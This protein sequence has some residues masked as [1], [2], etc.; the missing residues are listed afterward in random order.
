MYFEKAYGADQAP[1]PAAIY[2]DR[3]HL[4]LARFS[5]NDLGR[6]SAEVL[7]ESLR[8]F[9]YIGEKEQPTP[10]GTVTWLPESQHGQDRGPLQEVKSQRGVVRYI[11]VPPEKEHKEERE[12]EGEEE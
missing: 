11:R 7:L 12:E 6:E 9:S 5:A 4:P 8:R 1:T 3:A 10:T 2:A